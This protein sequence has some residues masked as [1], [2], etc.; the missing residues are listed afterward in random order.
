MTTTAVSAHGWATQVRQ[1]LLHGAKDLFDELEGSALLSERKRDAWMETAAG[2]G[3]PHGGGG[4]GGG[5]SSP[6]EEVVAL[7]DQMLLR[8]GGFLAQTGATARLPGLV[9]CGAEDAAAKAAGPRGV[10]Y[11]VPTWAALGAG[12]RVLRRAVSSSAAPADA[13]AAHLLSRSTVARLVAALDSRDVR[14]RELLGEVLQD[15][16]RQGREERATVRDEVCAALRSFALGTCRAEDARAPKPDPAHAGVS[17]LLS[18][19]HDGLRSTSNASF[20]AEHEP[21]LRGTLLLLHRPASLLAFR[22]ELKKCLQLFADKMGGGAPSAGAAMVGAAFA[23]SMLRCW[24][25]QSWEK[26]VALLLDFKEIVEAK[27]SRRPGSRARDAAEK[28][29]LPSQ[30]LA[31]GDGTPWLV[32]G[33]PSGA[34]IKV[35]QHIASLASDPHGEV[36]SAVRRL[37]EPGKLIS[38]ALLAPASPACAAALQRTRAQLAAALHHASEHADDAGEQRDATALLVGLST[39]LEA[40]PSVG[41]SAALPKLAAPAAPVVPAA[42]VAPVAPTA[43]TAA[44]A[45]TPAPAATAAAAGSAASTTTVEVTAAEEAAGCAAKEIAAAATSTDATAAVNLRLRWRS[46]RQGRSSLKQRLR[47]QMHSHALSPNHT[48]QRLR[49]G[50]AARESADRAAERKKELLQFRHE[51]CSHSPRQM[52]GQLPSF[53]PIND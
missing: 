30:L 46:G 17:N 44:T 15:L 33:P 45:D 50:V 12:W 35:L 49:S 21:L 31:P 34:G 1:A 22:R 13:R 43:T 19:L 10:V 37:L 11:D 26:Q 8:R 20:A 52:R 47:R 38:T 3:S 40:K 36:R 32:D 2:E 42:P 18:V 6:Y 29:A 9:T 7:L 25:R 23:D 39:A 53:F 14:E 51:H 27:K 48:E 24:P 5:G 28:A 16:A 41:S 4:G